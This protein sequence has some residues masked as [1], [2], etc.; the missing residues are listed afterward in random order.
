MKKHYKFE[1]TAKGF[2]LKIVPVFIVLAVVMSALAFFIVDKSVMPRVTN[3]QN[4]GDVTV[5]SVV[6][7]S[8]KE[9]STVLYKQSLI[10][11]K[12]GRE[13]SDKPQNEIL[14]QTP[15]SG[16]KV[17]GGHH[18][19][20]TMSRG[21][22]VGVVPSVAKLAEG[23]AKSLLRKEGFKTIKVRQKYDPRVSKGSAIETIPASPMKTSRAGEITLL[24][25]KGVRPTHTIAPS[26]V[27]DL[28]SVAQ[29]K[30]VDAELVVGRVT[31]AQNDFIGA[32]HIIKQSVAPGSNPSLRTKVNLVVSAE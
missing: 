27:G 6:G 11:S 21:P 7:L 3:L 18:I 16:K 4:K 30:I 5:P 8:Q 25:S 2:W 12:D 19:F 20:V 28:L 24:I 15:E 29:E 14:R 1:V 9:A 32:G 26:V 17:K 31:Y 13:Y 10:L 23:P 22:E